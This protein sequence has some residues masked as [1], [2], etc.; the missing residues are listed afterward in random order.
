M[1]R[2]LVIA[3]CICLW[4]ESA[5]AQGVQIE[6]SGEADTTDGTA[7]GTAVVSETPAV[8]A[9]TGAASAIP[10][11]YTAKL[12]YGHGLYLKGDY[13]GA[14]TVYRAA[15]D[16]KTTDPLPLYLIACA[17]AKLEQYDDAMITLSALK[18]VCG[19]KLPGLTA[20]GL[21]LT[22]I[23]EETR[24]DAENATLAWT[25][26][27]QFASDHS[28]IPAFVG[29]ADARLQALEKKRES[30]AQYKVVRE[31]ITGVTE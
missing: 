29:S 17:Q 24:G 11:G 6:L 22:A 14:L 21:F 25:A 15:K 2:R 12:D 4:A 28:G 26:Y 9:A 23:I 5:G 18:T 8:A 27:K 30:A 3:S 13:Q 10:E 31:R 19:E 1:I 16:S 20:R 7:E